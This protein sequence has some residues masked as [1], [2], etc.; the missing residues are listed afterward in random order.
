MLNPVTGLRGSDQDREE[1]QG[2]L[3]LAETRAEEL[4]ENL[5][6]MTFSMEQ[7]RAMAQSLEESLETE[8]QVRKPFEHNPQTLYG[9]LGSWKFINK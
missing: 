3:Q 9:S 2:R 1:L 8:K 4:A 5:K 6:V 7:Y